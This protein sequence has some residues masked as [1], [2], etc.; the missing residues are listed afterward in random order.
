MRAALADRIALPPRLAAAGLL[1]VV[2]LVAILWFVAFVVSDRLA[3]QR[4]AQRHVD[5]AAA[6]VEEHARGRLDAV[7]QL[8]ARVRERVGD[9]DLRSLR[10]SEED[11][12][13][14]REMAESLPIV[15]SLI[16]ADEH[17]QTQ[18][19]AR[20]FPTGPIDISDRDYFRAQL[21]KPGLF[22]GE[23]IVGRAAGEL[24]F[25]VSLP[26]TTRDGAFR[27]ILAATL[28][29]DTFREAYRTIGADNLTSVALMRPDGTTIVSYPAGSEPPDVVSD[30]RLA[31]PGTGPRDADTLTAVFAS[32][33]YPVVAAASLDARAA[34]A[35]WRRR[36]FLA[37]SLTVVG[38]GGSTLLFA[39]L[40][41]GL[42][43]ETRLLKEREAAHDEVRRINASLE[44]MLDHR[45]VLIRE[46]HHR[47][48][49]NIQMISSLLRLQLG[50]SPDPAVREALRITQSRLAAMADLHQVLYE[51]HESEEVDL[52]VFLGKLGRMLTE[53]YGLLER[54]LVLTVRSAPLKLDVDRAVIL[55]L[56]INEAVVNAAKHGFPAGR[57]GRIWI[58]LEADESAFSLE[59]ADDGVGPSEAGAEGRGGIGRQ[60]LD[61]LVAQLGGSQAL[62]ARHPV[63]ARFRLS[64]PRRDPRREAGGRG[65]GAASGRVPHAA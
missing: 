13:A 39:A 16:V 2:T 26:L 65:A 52:P 15:V 22:I 19:G 32:E 33:H 36:S 54:D 34:F 43:R 11:Y 18:L 8:L 61:A 41:R 17:G 59:V 51:S 62:T 57:G 56:I 23:T 42:Q 3:T 37:G 5:A 25:T 21:R 4:Q 7:T 40:S 55:G 44:K 14:V 27:G 10:F 48:K 49:N 64:F 31:P 38:L 35:R 47:A 20:A 46:T 6:L 28:D 50:K 12:L 1:A 9:R 58:A 53:A 60:L 63:G 29:A 45:A 24:V 30:G